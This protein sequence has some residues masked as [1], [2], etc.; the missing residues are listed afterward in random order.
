M[1]FAKFTH[2]KMYFIF[3]LSMVNKILTYRRIMGLVKK[4]V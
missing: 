3:F 4:S 2:E 1:H